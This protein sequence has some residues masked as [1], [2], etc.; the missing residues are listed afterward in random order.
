MDSQQRQQTQA[1]F[2]GRQVLIVDAEDTFTS[3]IAKQLRA[4]GLVVTV[5]S[6][7]DD[8]SFDGYD[9]VIMGP[10]PG[11]PSSIQLPK[12]RPSARCHPFLA[13][14]AAAVPRGVPESSGVEP[15]PGPGAATQG[16][17]QPG[18]TKKQIDLFGS[19][20][21]VGFY[22]TFAA[23]SSSDRLDIN[24]IGTVEISR[25]SAT[26]EVHA[27]RGPSFASMQFHAESLLTQEGPRI[28]ADLLRHALIHTPVDSNASAAGR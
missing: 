3:M 17:S 8:Y 19:A 4:L 10:G 16:H 26:G 15:V 23:Q 2:S 7:S 1:D 12:N 25:D 14:P 6:F 20:E 21:R 24:G 11:N 13:Q 5:C 28:I 9:L 18:R 27:L 22:N